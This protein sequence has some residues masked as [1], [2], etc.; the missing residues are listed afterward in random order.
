MN[1]FI[2]LSIFSSIAV[3]NAIFFALYFVFLYKG[4]KLTRSLLI[5]LI[6]AIA[7]R[8]GKSIVY[9]VFGIP[10][11]GTAI[12]GLG[13]FGIGVFGWFY[14]QNISGKRIG[15][16]KY[17]LLHFIP[18]VL[19]GA[20]IWGQFGLSPS[21][22]YSVGTISSFIYWAISFRLILKYTSDQKK[23]WNTSLLVG[24]GL[25]IACFAWQLFAI[26][27]LEYAI[28][29][30]LASLFVYLLL[31]SVLQ[32]SKLIT[33]EKNATHASDLKEVLNKINEA[34]EVQKVYRQN[35]LN[36][37]QLGE[38]IDV[39]VYKITKALTQNFGKTF[40][41]FINHYRVSEV[42]DKLVSPEHQ[43]LTI[44]GLAFDSGFN[45]PSSFYNAFKKEFGVTPK[46]YQKMAL[47]EESKKSVA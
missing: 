20:M 23:K 46:K 14:A 25:M 47:L 24:I 39:P 18:A 16:S 22:V 34:F 30:G 19:G 41:E 1:N 38:L 40:P 11:L 35:A 7:I 27:L 4:P 21:M 32:N 6:L 13:L 26:D 36:L 12:G 37:N 31:F 44:E 10:L 29:A 43:N 5:G 15:M 45:T 8:I 2:S 42:K 17:D 28:G 9:Y 3:A 33:K